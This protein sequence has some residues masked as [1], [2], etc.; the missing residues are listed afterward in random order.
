MKVYLIGSLRNPRIPAIARELRSVGLHVFDDWYAAG[1]EADDC[2]QKYEQ[3]KGNAF[4]LALYGQAANHVF[5]FDRDHLLSSDVV[6]LVTPA[7]KSA[8]MELGWAL[9]KGKKGY[10]LL[11]A[12]VDRWDVMYKFATGVFTTITDMVR[13]LR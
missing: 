8:H 11:D 12:P 6:I 5:E 13:T 3:A 10:V 7:G 4:P 2:W 9:G 1:P